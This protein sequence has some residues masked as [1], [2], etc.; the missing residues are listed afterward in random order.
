MLEAMLRRCA[1]ALVLLGVCASCAGK[2]VTHDAPDAARDGAAADDTD[3]RLD[4][5][6]IPTFDAASDAAS[7]AHR[8]FDAPPDKC[9]PFATVV[10]GSEGVCPLGSICVEYSGGRSPDPADAASDAP[11]D[12]V[13]ASGGHCVVVADGCAQG[14]PSTDCVCA[15]WLLAGTGCAIDSRRSCADSP[16]GIVP[17]VACSLP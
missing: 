3:G 9:P 14:C 4:V 11:S 6:G 15:A 7:D 13:V 17:L 10:C 12:A 1:L 8:T 16:S 5:G 2:S